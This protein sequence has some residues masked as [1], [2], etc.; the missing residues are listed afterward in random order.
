MSTAARSRVFKI[1]AA[2]IAIGLCLFS[3]DDVSVSIKGRRVERLNA[4]IYRVYEY[5]FRGFYFA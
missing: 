3:Q 1:S 2:A 5:G 4:Q